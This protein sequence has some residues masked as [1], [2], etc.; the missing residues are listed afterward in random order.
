[1]RRLFSFYSCMITCCQSHFS[2]FTYPA[3]SVQQYKSRWCPFSYRCLHRPTISSPSD[4]TIDSTR[5]VGTSEYTCINKALCT[6]W[7][8]HR[9]PKEILIR[10]LFASR[11]LISF[12]SASASDTNSKGI[13]F[14]IFRCHLS[15]DTLTSIMQIFIKYSRFLAS[16]RLYELHLVFSRELN[17]HAHSSF[18][19]DTSTGIHLTM[20]IGLLQLSVASRVL[21]PQRVGLD[22][23]WMCLDACSRSCLK[24]GMT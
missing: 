20:K 18:L 19:Y 24:T 2:C 12:L 13:A 14:Q 3:S 23:G 4:P 8:L 1:M 9:N 15:I 5:A 17:H 7:M 6:K 21:T 22:R 11:I 16:T 10:D